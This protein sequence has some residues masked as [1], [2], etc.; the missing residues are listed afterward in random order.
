MITV[1]INGNP[2]TIIRERG[3][4]SHDN[5]L[6]ILENGVEIRGKDATETQQFISR[7]IGASAEEF[8]T[9]SYF[10]E[11]S[12]AANF[13][14]AKAKDRRNLF[15]QLA[16]L[17]FPKDL[18]EKSA[19]AKK[20]TKAKLNQKEIEYATEK[21]KLDQLIESR[22]SLIK[23]SDEWFRGHAKTIIEIENLEKNY[24]EEKK[25]KKEVLQTKFLN[26][27]KNRD[28]YIAKLNKRI[29]DL[30]EVVSKYKPAPVKEIKEN[31]CKSCGQL[32]NKE[33]DNVW[34]AKMEEREHV[35]HVREKEVVEES[36]RKARNEVNT[37]QDQITELENSGNPYT[38]QLTREKKRENPF[39]EQTE[40][41][42]ARVSDTGVK[43]STLLSSVKAL[44]AKMSDLSQLYDLSSVLRAEL[45]KRTV[46]EIN[47]NVNQI[48]ETY[49][50]SELRV[51]LLLD[52]DNLETRIQ[53]SGFDCNY[54]QLSKGQRQLLRLSFVLSVQKAL[55]NKLGV[56]F[57][58]LFFDEALDGLDED[59]KIKSYSLFESLSLNHESILI[60]DHSKA[61][62]NMFSKKFKVTMIADR[63]SIEEE[64]EQP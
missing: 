64:Y 54:R 34:K 50:E 37:Y 11:F 38:D 56:C 1:E 41:A 3:N 53:K 5:D 29:S 49:F 40:S 27:E 13:F 20:V 59:L 43:V 46:G 47:D 19:A 14:V 22:N 18:A 8:I 10:H 26:F 35:S 52:E 48:L 45:L 24:D 9:A 17:E 62:H 21:G 16:P 51:T 7:R 57:Q 36:L 58:N 23:A 39:L 60:I 12:D 55:S 44:E 32:I 2:V 42:I 63:S 30:D 31:K 4:R 25:H 61:F 33:Q 28:S 15:E 6:Y